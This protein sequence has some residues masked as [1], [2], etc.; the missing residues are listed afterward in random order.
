MLNWKLA[1]GSDRR[2]VA[3]PYHGLSCH[4]PCYSSGPE[5]RKKSKWEG[6]TSHS[7]MASIGFSPTVLAWVFSHSKGLGTNWH[8][9]ILGFFGANGS[10]LQKG[11]LEG[12]PHCSL[13]LSP[14]LFWLWGANSF[15][16]EKVL[17]DLP[18]V[19]CFL[20]FS[21]GTGLFGGLRDFLVHL[22]SVLSPNCLLHLSPSVW[23][24]NL[25]SSLEH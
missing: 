18:T 4:V 13:H 3:A 24:Q 19:L 8:V 10:R 11:S 6:Q 7:N 1:R 21:G 12:S 5:Q 22:F 9:C 2:T 16:F 15:L 14:S 17:R 23:S 20:W 25:L